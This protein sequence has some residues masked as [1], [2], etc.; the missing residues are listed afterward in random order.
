MNTITQSIIEKFFD[1]MILMDRDTAT[2]NA[3]KTDVIA[4]VKCTGDTELK[5]GAEKLFRFLRYL[6][7]RRLAPA[8]IQRR[9]IGVLRCWRWAYRCG[10][11][12]K[13][14]PSSK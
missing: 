3:Y 2:A 1:H 13:P 6:R 10:I 4:Y 12:I 11:K 5:F 14:I 9:I 7:D 8:T